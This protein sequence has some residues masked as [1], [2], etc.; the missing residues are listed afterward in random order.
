MGVGKLDVRAVWGGISVAVVTAEPLAAIT[1]ATGMY[2]P[3]APL[4]ETHAVR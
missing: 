4:S 1:A 2:T 3:A